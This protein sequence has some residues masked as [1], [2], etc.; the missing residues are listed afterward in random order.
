MFFGH[1]T[2]EN[3]PFWLVETESHGE[4]SMCIIHV[5]RLVVKHRPL[6]SS[7]PW[8]VHNVPR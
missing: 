6:P 8:D 5:P 7:Q 4:L 1:K 3:C 2:N